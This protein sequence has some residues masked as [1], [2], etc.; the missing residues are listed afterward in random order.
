MLGDSGPIKITGANITVAGDGTVVSNDGEVGK[1]RV[2]RFA[3]S[4]RVAKEG[5]TLFAT[6]PGNV[7]EATD[8]RV[9]Q[10]SLEQSNVNSIDGMISLI[11]LNRQ[12]EVSQ[13]AMTLMDSVTQK[14][15]SAGAN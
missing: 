11:A 9:L 5:A 14:M 15:I 7:Q 1:I 8:P 12:F 13:R 4:R 2:V 10:G 3:D 6:A